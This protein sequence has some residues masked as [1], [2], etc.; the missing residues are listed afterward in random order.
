MCSLQI[1]NCQASGCLPSQPHAF[2]STAI[3]RDI[4]VA[5]YFCSCGLRWRS[6]E[7]VLIPCFNALAA[8]ILQLWTALSKDTA[9]IIYVHYSDTLQLTTT[10]EE[11]ACRII[12]TG[13]PANGGMTGAFP[14]LSFENG[15]QKGRKC[16]YIKGVEAGTFWG[17]DFLPACPQ[18]CR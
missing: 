5:L 17:C 8:D 12:C 18:T 4:R 3:R 7:C 2:W 16:I 14:P 15:G 6:T 9:D 13:T 10:S 11:S 1:S